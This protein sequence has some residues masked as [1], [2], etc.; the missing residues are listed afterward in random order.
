[1]STVSQR[2][3]SPRSGDLEILGDGLAGPH[4]PGIGFADRNPSYD[5]GG[6]MSEGDEWTRNRDGTAP[7]DFG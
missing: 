3:A 5:E 6:R 1:M 7:W 4:P 2:T